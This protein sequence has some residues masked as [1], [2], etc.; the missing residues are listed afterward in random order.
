MIISSNGFHEELFSTL[1]EENDEDEESNIN[2]HIS[3]GRKSTEK[4]HLIIED[5]DNVD[6]KINGGFI[7][8]GSTPRIHFVI[9]DDNPKNWENSLWTI[10][11]LLERFGLDPNSITVKKE[12]GFNKE[13]L[14]SELNNKVGLP[15]DNN[16]EEDYF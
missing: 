3:I 5:K 11:Q 15:F 10:E 8:L 7:A 14:L 6:I 16:I 9:N 1:Q 13:Y 12:C 2:R 4:S